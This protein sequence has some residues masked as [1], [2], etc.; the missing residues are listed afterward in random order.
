MVRFVMDAENRPVPDLNERLPGRG[1][2]LTADY[3]LI[4]KAS[5]KNLFAK[6]TRKHVHIDYDIPELLV[7]LMVRRCIHNL[8]LAKRAGHVL[9]GF[10]ELKRALAQYKEGYV[11]SARDGGFSNRKKLFLLA[12]NIPILDSL[13]ATEIGTAFGRNRVVHAFI[14]SGGIG[15]SLFRDMGRLAGLRETTLAA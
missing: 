15:D 2:W 11:F 13:T 1:L 5:V 12:K 7:K 9:I 4:N 10:D 6:K 14:S 8:G 3:R